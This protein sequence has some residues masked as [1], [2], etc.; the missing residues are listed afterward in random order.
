MSVPFQIISDSSCDLAP[1][2]VSEKNIHVVPFYVSP[3][4]N[5]YYKEA[6]EIGIRDFYQQLV[7]HPGVFP[8]SSMPS[9]QDYINAFTPYVEQNIPVICVCITTKFSG[10]YNSAMNAAQLVRE[11]YPEAKIEVI[12]SMVNTVLQGL[13][14]L[15]L[16]RMR[17]AGLSFEKALRRIKL[18]RPSARIL[19]TIA[20]MDYLLSGGR[21]GKLAGNAAAAL[22]LKPMIVLK[23]GEIFPTGITRNREK[24]K[25]KLVTQVRNHFEK[26]G[27]SPDDYALCIGYGYDRAEAEAFRDRL[28]ADMKTYSHVTTI[29][30]SQI[31]AT[32]AVHTGPHPIGVGLIKRYDA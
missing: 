27:E 17:D 6:E 9:V 2:I 10:S 21:V 14:T 12:N 19:F 13:L 28:L 20:S 25:D 7:D 22:K 30:L 3:D 4:G 31:G 8:K 32:I 24:S 15:E 18:I 29:P 26:T 1:E 5:Q 16:V 23:E 11:D